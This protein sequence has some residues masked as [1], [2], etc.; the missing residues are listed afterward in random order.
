MRFTLIHPATETHIRKYS[1]QK[2]R[3]V[4]ET[5]EVYDK[6]VKKYVEEKR[7]SGRLNWVYNI[8]DGKAERDRVICEDKDEEW[9]WVVLPDS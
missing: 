3:A 6:Y 9:G 1:A 4:V 5:P 8:L 2:W 7:G